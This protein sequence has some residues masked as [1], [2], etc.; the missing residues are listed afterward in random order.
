[1]LIGTSAKAVRFRIVCSAMLLIL[2]SHSADMALHAR[3]IC[4]LAT[5]TSC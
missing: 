5:A 3:L 2:R 4:E 1:M